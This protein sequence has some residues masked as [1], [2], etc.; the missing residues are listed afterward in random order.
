MATFTLRELSGG[1]IKALHKTASQLLLEHAYTQYTSLQDTYDI[2]MSHSYMD[3]DLI[4]NIYY[5]LTNQFRYSV[6]IDWIDDPFLDRHEVTMETAS[7]IRD[8][9]DRC[10]SLFYVRT[11]NSEDSKWMPWECGYFDGIKHRVAIL[12]I[13]E[14][15]TDDFTGQEYLSLYPYITKDLIKNTT[16]QSLWVNKS[17]NYYVSFE[18]WL[19]GKEPIRH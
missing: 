4:S 19:K 15:I 9:M 1:V 14:S 16:N 2:F 7:I 8:R 3:A 5:V 6:Y 13:T 12:P 18:E 10:S 11:E 17:S